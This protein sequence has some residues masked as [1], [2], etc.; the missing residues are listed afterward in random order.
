MEHAVV[1]Q[2]L[3]GRDGRQAALLRHWDGA[4]RVPAKTAFIYVPGARG[5]D[6]A[7]GAREAEWRIPDSAVQPG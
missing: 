6:A 3:P 5:D 4:V 1:T 7:P 2:A